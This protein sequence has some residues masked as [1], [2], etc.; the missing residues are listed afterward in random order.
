MNIIRRTADGFYNLILGMWTT[1]Q[2]LFSHA[3]TLQY[4]KERWPMPE[5]SRGV[6][7]LM[8]DPETGKLKCIDEERI[9]SSP[10]V[11]KKDPIDI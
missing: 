3:I 4:P 8:S 9:I 10:I 6:V 11:H 1:I 2:Y 7:S 5:R